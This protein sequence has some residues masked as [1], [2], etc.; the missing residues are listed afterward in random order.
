MDKND[1]KLLA[2]GTIA[3]DK[4]LEPL[5]KRRAGARAAVAASSNSKGGDEPSFEESFKAGD[6]RWCWWRW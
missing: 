6:I 1:P 3:R 5:T 4:L 2:G